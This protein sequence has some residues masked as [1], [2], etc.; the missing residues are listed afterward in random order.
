MGV[1][2]TTYKTSHK[3]R[4]T[5]GEVAYRVTADAR[6]GDIIN[7]EDAANINRDTEHTLGEGGPRDLV[8]VLLLLKGFGGRDDHFGAYDNRREKG[9]EISCNVA[10]ASSPVRDTST[11]DETRRLHGRDQV[12]DFWEWHGGDHV[13]DI[14]YDVNV[15]SANAT[16]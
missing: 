10:T 15:H 16:V 2:S 9:G 12:D 5:W 1:H 7:I 11:G 6:S 13:L 4:P 8:T 14:V 3:G